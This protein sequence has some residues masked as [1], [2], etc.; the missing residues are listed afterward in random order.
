MKILRSYNLIDTT[1]EKVIVIEK[2]TRGQH[3]NKTMAWT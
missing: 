1:K 3:Q 2:A